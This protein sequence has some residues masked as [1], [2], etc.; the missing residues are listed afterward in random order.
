MW[1]KNLSLLRF[2]EPFKLTLEELE[3]Q[4]Q[5]QS[6]K[7]CGSLDLMSYGWCQPLGSQ[8]SFVHATNGY[9]MICAQKEEKI[10]P[11]SVINEM[12]AEKI[13][14]EEARKGTPVRKK[15]REDMRD[16]VIHS[17]LPR[18]F[19]HSRRTFAYLDP[20]G[21]WL[22]IDS[23]SA[24]KAEDLTSLLRQSIESLPVVYPTTKENPS[25]L[26]TRWLV[27]GHHPIDINIEDE[28]ELRSPE[29]DGGIVSCKRQDLSAPEIQTHFEAG[30]AVIKLALTW[31]ER[32]S[33]VLDEHLGIKRLRFLDA[34]QDQAA[35]VETADEAERFDADFSIMSLELAGFIPR[36]LEIFGGE[37][38]PAS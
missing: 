13:A 26:M 16:E 21:G 19:S 4:L 1:F 12:L 29:E 36:L 9:W 24:K 6:F 17:L 7:P 10:L 11:A 3:E 33:F 30:K 27:E 25:D 28:C 35:D 22:V 34:I 37:N 15:E 8:G 23:P 18:A 31:N 14:D 2:T 38:N 5:A 32:L 20:Q